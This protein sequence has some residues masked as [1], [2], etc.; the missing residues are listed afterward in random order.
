LTIKQQEVYDKEVGDTDRDENLY[1]MDK[2]MMEFISTRLGE[3]VGKSNHFDYGFIR[4]FLET[5]GEYE[6]I[7][8]LREW[9]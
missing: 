6:E 9:G 1:P 4:V 2:E 5:L 3:K 8:M 7:L